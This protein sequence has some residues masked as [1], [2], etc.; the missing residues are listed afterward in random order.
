MALAYL[1]DVFVLAGHR[2][3]GIGHL[4]V[5]AAMAGEGR[6]FR[7]LLHTNPQTV[8]FYTE[9]GY[10]DSSLVVLERPACG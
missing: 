2:G 8:G 6:R 5:A 4:V 7:W 3:R 1:A 9:H 10:G